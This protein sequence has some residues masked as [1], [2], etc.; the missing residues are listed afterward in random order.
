MTNEKG[1]RAQCISVGAI[2]SL[3]KY[4]EYFVYPNGEDYFY[5]SKFP[6]PQKTHFGCYSRLHFKLREEIK[7]IEKE[8]ATNIP[9]KE[10]EP[11]PE[12]YQQISLF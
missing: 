4:E 1:Y 10:V 3:E 11:E 8:A 7:E 6:Y 2:L 9:I 12:N 5:V